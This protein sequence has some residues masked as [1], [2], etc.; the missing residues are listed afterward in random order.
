MRKKVC[1]VGAVGVPACYGG[2]ETLLEYLVESDEVDFTVYCSSMAYATK[3]PTYKGA[4]LKYLPLA[5]NGIQSVLYDA[6]SLGGCLFS[7]PNVVLILGVSGCFFL[8]FFRFFSNAKIVTNIDGLEWRRDKWGGLA[9]KFLRWSEA[10]AVKYSDVIISDNKGI[11]DYVREEY[12]IDSEII[13]YGGDHVLARS[14]TGKMLGYA[15]SLCRIE[16]ENNVHVILDSFSMSSKPLKFVGNWQASEYGQTLKKKFSS[17]PHIE[18]IEPIYELEKLFDL[19]DGCDFYVH[20]HSAGGTNPSLVEAMFFGKPIIA[21]DCVYNRST[22][23]GQGV[24]FSDS[25]SLLE[26]VSDLAAFGVSNYGAVLCE[27]AYRRYTWDAVR[28][29]YEEILAN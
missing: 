17:C 8:P 5:A 12:F 15:F 25:S 28:R 11:A 1:V 4:S 6:L 14:P 13:A 26:R 16:P 3:I 9:K 29:D 2:F 10:I 24:Y 23:E 7:K 18:L 20:G 27:I 22:M 21:Y 19:R